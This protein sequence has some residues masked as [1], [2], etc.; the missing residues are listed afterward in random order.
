MTEA[1][2][3][4]PNPLP[5]GE[6][7]CFRQSSGRFAPSATPFPE[8]LMIHRNELTESPLPAGEG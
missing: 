1:V 7:T 3:P 4:H 6:G 8:A 5:L 2:L